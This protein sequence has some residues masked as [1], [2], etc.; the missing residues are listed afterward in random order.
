MEKVIIIPARVHSNR[1]PGKVLYLIDGLPLIIRT[2]K[3]ALQVKDC[4]VFIASDDVSLLATCQNE[5]GCNVI[6]TK[7]HRNGTER[8]AEAACILNLEKDDLILNLQADLPMIDPELLEN[9]FKLIPYYIVTAAVETKGKPS[10]SPHD[11]KVVMDRNQNALYF[12]RSVI[13]CNAVVWHN[14]IGV[15]GFMNVLLQEYAAR[16]ISSLELIEDLEQLRILYHGQYKVKVIVTKKDCVSINVP[17][18]IDKLINWPNERV[19]GH[20]I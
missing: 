20:V 13:P 6:L 4:R 8:C 11:V 10:Q 5:Y 14:H 15:Y 17:S 1:F 12:S 19:I 7:E 16:S 9:V 18:D 3:Q 2:W